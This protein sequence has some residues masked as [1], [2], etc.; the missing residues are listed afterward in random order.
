MLI[1]AV[2]KPFDE[3]GMLQGTVIVPAPISAPDMSVRL[4]LTCEIWVQSST[5]LPL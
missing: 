4:M 5:I 1:I 2:R 3:L